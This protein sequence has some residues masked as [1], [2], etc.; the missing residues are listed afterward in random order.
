MSGPARKVIIDCDPGIDDAIALCLA[1]FEPTLDVLA[2]TAVEGCVSAHQANRNVQGILEQLDPSR[3][4]RLGATSPSEN[5]PAVNT[6]YL[7]GDQGLGNVSWEVS[8]LHHQ[9]PAEKI[10]ADII[11]ANPGDVT[12]ISLGPMTN[13]ARAFQRDPG[14]VP[15]VDRLFIMGGS[16]TGIGNITANAEFNVYY[17]PPSARS[18][19]RSRTTKTLLPLDITRQVVWYMDLLDEM[20]SVA[21]RVGRLLKG[22][23]PYAFRSYRQQMGQEGI[24]LNDVIALMV[25][26]HPDLVQTEELAGDVEETGELTRGMTVF[27]RRPQPEW[28]CNMEVATVIDVPRVRELTIQALQRA[29]RLTE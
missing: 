20:P 11:R 14:L 5:S 10:M 15:L 23:L 7:H 12:I 4:P 21:S 16:L 24:Y 3:I 22:L 8:E 2:V 19:F 17:D 27:D 26:V 18:I 1:L 13:I 28:T 25:A 9:H 6:R 29:G